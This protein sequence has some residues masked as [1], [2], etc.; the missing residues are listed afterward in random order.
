MKRIKV[1]LSNNF[2]NTEITLLGVPEYNSI[3]ELT[4]V[5]ISKAQAKKAMN[6]LCPSKNCRCSYNC[7]TRGSQ[8]YGLPDPGTYEYCGYS[9]PYMYA[10]IPERNGE[11]NII[12]VPC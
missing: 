12:V 5:T 7:G 2:H 11:W 9:M 1:T 3:G 6:T 4:K 8:D 10:L